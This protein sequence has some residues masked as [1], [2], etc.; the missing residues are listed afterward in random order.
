VSAVNDPLF[1]LCRSLP[2]VTEDVKWENDLVFSVGEKMFACFGLP[3]ADTLSFKVEEGLF[4]SLVQ[5]EGIRPAPY[6]AKHGWIALESREALPVDVVKDLLEASHA[7]VAAKLPKKA[8]R[9]LGLLS[10][11]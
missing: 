3:D 2:G 5:K 8:Q 4:E 10:Q 6:L 7:L 11:A 1:D 9:K